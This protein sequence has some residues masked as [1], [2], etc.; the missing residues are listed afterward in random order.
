MSVT[1]LRII[2]ASVA[3]VIVACSIAGVQCS[4]FTAGFFLGVAWCWMTAE[5]LILLDSLTESRKE[6]SR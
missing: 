5:A 4:S 6:N 2:T 1:H 3:S